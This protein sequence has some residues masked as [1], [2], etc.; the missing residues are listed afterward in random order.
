[1]IIHHL[2]SENFTQIH[3]LNRAQMIDD[4]LNLARAGLL[5]Y[6]IALE[7]T[8]YLVQEVDYAPWYSAFNAFTFLDDKLAGTKIYPSFQVTKVYMVIQMYYLVHF[9]MLSNLLK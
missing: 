6:T 5:D 8:S 2:K 7:L 3:L 1:M 9:I 4:A